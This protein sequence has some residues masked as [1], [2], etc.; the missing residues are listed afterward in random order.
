MKIMVYIFSLLA[1]AAPGAAL[2]ELGYASSQFTA[3]DLP[4]PSAEMA[5]SENTEL[6]AASTP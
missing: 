5:G 4:L 6:S 3:T 1:L 2:L